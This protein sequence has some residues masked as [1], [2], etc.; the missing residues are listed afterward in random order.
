MTS[1]RPWSVDSLD[2]G[3]ADVMKTKKKVEAHFLF[4]LASRLYLWNYWTHKNGSP[5]K[6]CTIIDS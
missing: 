4:I 1:I 5:I 2:G 6:I 3:S